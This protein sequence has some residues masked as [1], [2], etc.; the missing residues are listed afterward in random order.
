MGSSAVVS[1]DARDDDTPPSPAAE[2][3][4]DSGGSNGD[5]VLAIEVASRR[6]QFIWRFGEREGIAK[7]VF[8]QRWEKSKNG[9]PSRYD[10]H[11]AQF[12][13]WWDTTHP[14]VELSPANIRPGLLAEYLG[15]KSTAGIHHDVLRDIS[16]SIYMA[17]AT[18]SDK[19]HLPGTAY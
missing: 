13:E 16:T 15:L 12:G 18:A 14:T 9:Y 5:P 2:R 1:D 7:S 10:G 19:K 11:F 8:E 3:G 4:M 17:C 6:R